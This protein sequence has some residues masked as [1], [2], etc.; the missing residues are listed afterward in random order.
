MISKLSLCSLLDR[1]NIIRLN[2]DRLYEKLNIEL[3]KKS[4]ADPNRP[5]KRNQQIVTDEDSYI[6]TI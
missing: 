3:I 4:K 5:N 2:F 6:I 1:D